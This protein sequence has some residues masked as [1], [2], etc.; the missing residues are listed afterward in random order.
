MVLPIT[1]ATIS[2]IKNP[3]FRKYA[4]IYCDIESSFMQQIAD[5]GLEVA[6]PDDSCDKLGE[7]RLARLQKLGV[8][9]ENDAKSFWL[10]W[11]SPACLSCRLGE[12]TE[13]FLAST[14]C[15]RDCFFCFNPNQEGYE[16]FLNHVHDVTTDLAQRHRAG[17]LYTDLALTGGEPLLHL[18]ETIAFF[19]KS[20]ELYPDAYTRLYT[21]GSGLDEDA[22]AQ[23]KAAGLQEIRFSIKTEDPESVQEETLE[24]IALAKD[25]IQNVLIEMPVM[26]D[27]LEQMKSLLERLNTIGIDGI[28]LLE[29]CFPF[30]NAK[31]FARRGYKIKA[32]PYRVLYDYWYAGGLPIAGSEKNCL[33]LLEFAAEKQLTMGVHYCSL[34]NKFTGQIY[35]Q[36]KPFMSEFNYCSLSEKDHFLKSAKVFGSDVAKVEKLLRAAGKHFTKNSD[37]SFLEFYVDD[38]ALLKRHYPDVEVAICSHVVEEREGAPTLRELHLDLIHAEEDATY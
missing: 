36:N 31:E 28:N 11:I 7:E 33:E 26:P 16:Y 38:V 4:Q 3:S 5:F 14:R 13:T 29:L 27:N 12:N 20:K 2:M 30:N 6:T 17:V 10:N 35:Q 23:L 8:Q 24:L 9:I 22:L 25:F 19:T 21:S 1:A 18:P 34:E 32:R 37:Y 15:T